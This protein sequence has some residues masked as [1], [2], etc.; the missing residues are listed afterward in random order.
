MI[1]KLLVVDLDETLTDP[2]VYY[3]MDGEMLKNS[4]LERPK[5]WSL[6][7]RRCVS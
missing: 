2:G 4:T 3:S 5:G 6:S 7:C 1:L